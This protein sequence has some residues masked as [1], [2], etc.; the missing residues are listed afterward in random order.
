MSVIVALYIGIVLPTFL[1]R[2]GKVRF[3]L[4]E[5]KWEKNESNQEKKQ[6][7]HAFQR[8]AEEDDNNKKQQRNILMMPRLPEGEEAEQGV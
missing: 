1:S 4:K 5:T 3:Q 6:Q 7:G 2:T 8:A